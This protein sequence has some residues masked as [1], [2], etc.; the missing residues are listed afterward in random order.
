[1]LI[2]DYSY[3]GGVV[4]KVL[5]CDDDKAF[6]DQLTIMINTYLKDRM[7]KYEIISTTSAKSVIDSKDVFDLAFLDIQM[8]EYNG[9]QVA[10]ELKTR[11]KNIIIFFVTDYN[12][13]QDDA[14]DLRVFRFFNKPLNQERVYSGLD[15]ALDYLNTNL[16]EIFIKESND[17]IKLYVND[18]CYVKRENRR[19]YV[20]TKDKTYETSESWDGWSEK[21]PQTY[22]YLVHNS[23]IINLHYVTKYSYTEIYVN[24]ER[25][26]IATRKQ[27][28]FRKY[29]F[30]YLRGK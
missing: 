16:T 11:N 24:D 28:D 14:M 15:K 27:A 10:Q 3:K 1:M 12:E 13:F 5:L 25:I 18:I 8:S 7:V 21:L 20:V 17:H 29:W 19:I 26:S 23:F 22:F 4:L 30:N 6:L 2:Y 9:L